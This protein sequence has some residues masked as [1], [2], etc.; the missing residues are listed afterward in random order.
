MSEYSGGLAKL[1]ILPVVSGPCASCIGACCLGNMMM[2]LTNREKRRLEKAGAVFKDPTPE[3]L[4]KTGSFFRRPYSIM[5]G[6][7]PN[8]DSETKACKDY[9]HRPQVCGALVAGEEDCNAIREARGPE[10]IERVAPVLLGMP[11]MPSSPNSEQATSPNTF[12]LAS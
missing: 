3:E 4:A 6:P 10:V 9:D 5:V 12:P 1:E 8:F 2:P 11:T 7:C